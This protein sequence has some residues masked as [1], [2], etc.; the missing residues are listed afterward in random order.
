M[1]KSRVTVI[2]VFEE[3]KRGKLLGIITEME[4]IKGYQEQK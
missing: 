2:P 4:V 3:G 1:H